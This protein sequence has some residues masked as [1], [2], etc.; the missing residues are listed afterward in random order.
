VPEWAKGLTPPLPKLL[1]DELRAHLEL[2]LDWGPEGDDRL[3]FLALALA[4]EAG[5]LANFVKKEWR[6]GDDRYNEIVSDD[7]RGELCPHA[8]AAPRYRSVVRNV[9]KVD[10]CRSAPKLEG[11]A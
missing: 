10:C 2:H 8:C 4:G 11:R 7:R 3:R 1:S 5:E 9:G 6:D